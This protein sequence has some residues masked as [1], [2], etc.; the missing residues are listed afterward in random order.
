MKE[1]PTLT[2][3]FSKPGF[4]Q[5]VLDDFLDVRSSNLEYFCPDISA[6]LNQSLPKNQPLIIRLQK[7]FSSKSLPRLQSARIKPYA[8]F[9]RVMMECILRNRDEDKLEPMKA[10]KTIMDSLLRHFATAELNPIQRHHLQLIE[11]YHSFC[12]EEEERSV[13]ILIDLLSAIAP[14]QHFILAYMLVLD[15]IGIIGQV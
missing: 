8:I 1:I 7:L 3:I 10:M 5:E 6:L 9:C 15:G 11:A 4:N 13:Q 2:K 14:K 12:C